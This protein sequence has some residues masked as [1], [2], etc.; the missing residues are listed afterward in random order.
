MIVQRSI[1]CVHFPSCSQSDSSLTSHSL[2]QRRDNSLHRRR[3]YGLWRTSRPSSIEG[4]AT[5]QD[6][7][8]DA[9]LETFRTFSFSPWTDAS[10]FCY[11]ALHC[12]CPLHA[13]SCT[14][15]RTRHSMSRSG[16]RRLLCHQRSTPFSAP[17]SIYSALLS[18]V[19]DGLSGEA[20][21]VTLSSSRPPLA[22]A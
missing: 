3:S 18:H 13:C 11:A 5:R 16:C 10:L 14:V 1:E 7:E 20:C 6:R 17:V 2:L 19:T 22:G 8:G 12:A 9:S 21:R 4:E 15:G